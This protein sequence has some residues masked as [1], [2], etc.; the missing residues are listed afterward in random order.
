[1]PM[2]RN[3]PLNEAPDL[4]KSRT[5]AIIS[6]AAPPIRQTKEAAFLLIEKSLIFPPFYKKET[7]LLYKQGR[8]ALPLPCSLSSCLFISVKLA[9]RIVSEYLAGNILKSVLLKHCMPS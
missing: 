3:A 8:S 7:S 2:T 6:S 5:S 9:L 4:L 1:M